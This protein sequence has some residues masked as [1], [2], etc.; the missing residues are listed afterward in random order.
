MGKY[1]LKKYGE[2]GKDL[3]TPFFLLFPIF[4]NL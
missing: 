2:N 4:A 3:L 1:E